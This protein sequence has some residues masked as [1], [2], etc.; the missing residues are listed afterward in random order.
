MTPPPSPLFFAYGTLMRGMLL[1]RW[2]DDLPLV[3]AA[4]VTGRLYLP[5][6]Y[7]AYLPGSGE[8]HGEIYDLSHHPERWDVLDAVEGFDPASPATSLYV[9]ET[10]T[11]QTADGLRRIVSLYRFGRPVPVGCR[12]IAGGSYRDHLADTA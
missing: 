2:T 12:V 7:P 5:S 10:A 6:W 11:A 1:S 8:V 9:R 4:T 3:G